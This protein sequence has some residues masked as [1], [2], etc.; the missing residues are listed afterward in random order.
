M[1]T[2]A[3]RS[4]RRSV[5]STRTRSRTTRR[6]SPP[7]SAILD[8][9][10]D[11]PSALRSLDRIYVRNEMW[12]ELADI[13]G[14]Q[15]T[16]VGPEDDQPGH[17]E[18]KFRLGQLRE[19]HLG[20]VAGRDRRV[21]RHP[22]PRCRHTPRRARRSRSISAA[23]TSRSWSS[24]ASSSRSTSS[25]RSGRRSS[26]STRSSS[27]PSKDPLQRTSLLLRI[28]ELQRTKLV[29]RRAG[30]RRLRARVPRGSVDRGGQGPARGA[31]T[32]H[33]G[34]LGTPGQAVRGRAWQAADLDGRLAHELATKVA[35]S[36][37]DRLGDSDKAVE[38]FRKALVDRARR[39]RARSPR[40]SAI[41]TRD[42]K[43]P[44][45]LEVYRRRIDIANEPDERLDFLFRIA[46]IH[47]EM[48]NAPGRGDRDLQRDPR[49]GAGR[50]EG[51]ARPRSAVRPARS[52]WRDLG[53]NLSRQ[54]TLVE[55]PYEQVAL[56]VR[57]AQ[58][59]ETHLDEIAAAVETYRQVLDH[60]DREP[61]RGGRARAADRQP[62]ARAHDR[63]HPRADLQGPR[64]VG[65]ADRRVRDHGEAR[66]RSGAQDRAAPPDRRAARDRR[67]RRRT[68]RSRPSRARCARTRATRPPTPSSIASPAGSTTGPTL[69]ALYDEVA[70]DGRRRTTSRSRCC[71]G[72]RRSR[73]PSSATTRRAV[74]TYERMLKAAPST[75]E[76][77]TAI[78]TI[79]ERTGDYPKL[80]AALKRKAEIVAEPRRAQGSCCIA[81]RRSRRRSSATR[82][83]RS[84]PSARCCR[85]TTST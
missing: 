23:T 46:S 66:L 45:L 42:E 21:P 44:E 80:V 32:A 39:P 84:R 41:F 8:A 13:L 73:S 6:R 77:A 31:V 34:R 55:Q 48:L 27:R 36:Y 29:R 16:I 61:R 43:Y 24:P 28:G 33:R 54:L 26:A 30:V 58:L 71:S 79:H 82:T 59:R 38:F 60:E 62:G 18:L 57:L 3:S 2:S 69:A 64:R 10:G 83:P 52:T 14:R 1:A 51:A 49:P 4:S 63:E 85:S 25:S 37:E 76:A 40:S 50:S 65:Q 35:R 7:T 81:R 68:P 74:A 12:K 5:S 15:I 75:V 72:A 78:Q 19:Q 53:D 22:R 11:E 17:V 9:A 47:E 70:S 20:D 56:L 67:R